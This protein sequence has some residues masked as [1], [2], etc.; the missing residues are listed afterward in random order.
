M[1]T[2]FLVRLFVCFVCISLPFSTIH[3]F[4]VVVLVRVKRRGSLRERRLGWKPPPLLPW[5]KSVPE[6]VDYYKDKSG[7]ARPWLARPAF[8]SPQN[9]PSRKKAPETQKSLKFHHFRLFS[10]N[11]THFCENGQNGPKGPRRRPLA[12]SIVKPIEYWW[13]RGLFGPGG[14]FWARKH[15]FQPKSPI[16][17]QWEIWGPKA[18][19][20]WYFTILGPDG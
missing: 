19:F 14:V 13:F 17:W 1:C 6:F 10:Q 12:Q 4:A 2:Y 11:S 18:P 9:R 7:R 20:S 16:S 5:D 3:S 15:P 8:L